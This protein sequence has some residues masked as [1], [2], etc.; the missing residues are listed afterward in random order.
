[1][2]DVTAATASPEERRRAVRERLRRLGWV[3]PEPVA[4]KGGYGAARAHAG[5]LWVS[6]HTGRG[7]E[8]P[9]LTGTVGD[10]V[11]VEL[12]REE[13][14][15]AAMNLLAAVDGCPELAAGLGSVEALLHLRVFVRGVPGFNQHSAVAD[16][17]SDLLREAFGPTVGTHARTAVGAGSLPGCSAV[18]LEA[19]LAYA[20]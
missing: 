19:V 9:R 10:D 13:A 5:Q 12:A 14:Q 15:R 16:A 8:G 11:T 1:M 4:S 7:T 2:V 17:A 3:L 6:G 20:L 18:E